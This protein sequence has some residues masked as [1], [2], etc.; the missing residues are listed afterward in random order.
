M[1]A[2]YVLEKGQISVNAND[3]KAS[4][5]GDMLVVLPAYNEAGS[6]REVI[7]ELETLH[8]S[9]DLLVVDDGS[10]DDT[11]SIAQSAGA[12]VL[13]MPFNCGIGASVQ[14][15]AE[16]TASM[17]GGLLTLIGEGDLFPSEIERLYMLVERQ[18]SVQ[19]SLA[20]AQVELTREQAENMRLQ[21]E[22]I[23]RG[24]PALQVQVT[25]EGDTEGWL[26]GLMESL[27]KEIMV[28]ASSEAFSF[29]GQG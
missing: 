29:I 26:S 5:D 16:T 8:P 23:R 17:F 9:A 21:N 3:I 15:T 1:V 14:A 4:S 10:D 27:F 6:I 18:L 25:V 22:R 28:K 13:R 2:T 12:R 20:A 7:R 19:E 24:D 11:A